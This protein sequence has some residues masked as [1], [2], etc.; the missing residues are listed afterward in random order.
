MF[1][2]FPRPH[3]LAK[4]P[5]PASVAGLPAT[6]LTHLETAA[7]DEKYA[8]LVDAAIAECFQIS[9][10]YVTGLRQAGDPG[11][12]QLRH[13]W[14]R[15]GEGMLARRLAQ[16]AQRKEDRHRRLRAME[17]AREGGVFRFAP[18]RQ[19]AA[20]RQAAPAETE[21]LSSSH[22]FAERSG[23]KLFGFFRKNTI[24]FRKDTIV[25][26]FLLLATAYFAFGI[27]YPGGWTGA[28]SDWAG[29]SR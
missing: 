14:L 10:S 24:A 11:Y 12:W 27:L 25:I 19:A 29:V 28:W 1:E 2:P 3:A 20:Y 4:A 26:G 9:G 7:L 6:R 16:E 8:G 23:K 5:R 22:S 13:R 17:A 18:P 15:E 21:T